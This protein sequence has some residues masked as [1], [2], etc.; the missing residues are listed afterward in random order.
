MI[1]CSY[2]GYEFNEKDTLKGCKTCPMTKVCN[3]YKCPNCGFHIL[4]EPK[5]IKQLK[6]WVS[7]IGFKNKNR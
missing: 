1:K 6:K 7:K 3:K 2:C 5:I 4:K